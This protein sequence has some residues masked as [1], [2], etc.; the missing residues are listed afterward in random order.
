MSKTTEITA[1]HTPR[2]LAELAGRGRLPASVRNKS[3]MA[4]IDH[5]LE[6]ATTTDLMAELAVEELYLMI[7]DVGRA[8][9]YPL[10]EFATR[11]QLQGL[12]DLDMWHKG[13]P[14]VTRWLEWLD[15]TFA[16][17]IDTAIEFIASNDDETLEWL[18]IKDVTIHGND[19]D[20]ST[21]DDAFALLES[22]DGMYYVTIPQEHELTERLPQIMRL[23][24][25]AD[26]DRARLIFD[27]ARFDLPASV[28]EYMLGFRSGRLQD[29]GFLSEAEAHTVFARLNAR[30]LRAEVRGGLD[31]RP[32]VRP[33]LRG[34]ILE[35]L[36]LRGV[37]PPNLLGAALAELGDSARAAF[38]EA[39]TYLVNQVFM[40]TTGDLSRTDDLPTAG[41][42]AAALVNLGLA[43]VSD[44]HV[45]TAARALT[46]VWP[47]ELFRAGHTLTWEVGLR[48][49][50]V[51][52]RAGVDRGLALFGSPIDEALHGLA[53]PHPLY[54]MA[55]D[56]PA[57]PDFRPLSTLEELA[58]V[59]VLVEDADHVLRFFEAQLGFTPERVFDA[60]AL[61]SLSDQARRDVRL[62]TLLRTGL[63]HALL[64]DALSFDPVGREELAAFARAAF[65]RE[66]LLSAPF[67]AALEA[68]V[69]GSGDAVASFVR[70]SVDAFV[71]AMGRVAPED[72]D[73][74]FA[75]ELVLV[76]E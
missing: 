2:D 8:D 6:L 30:D 40:A 64:T 55:I 66:G 41:R 14:V 62:A 32:E 1:P 49:R 3:G 20:T 44:D 28:E 37:T 17:S 9:A 61:A 42:H 15:L 50:R 16:A 54:A 11:E 71:D 58:R 74:R 47:K 73:P 24:W 13:A 5:L 68:M 10:L 7:Q 29:M 35:D 51:Q 63:V 59:E 12:L 70:R 60:P 67:Q 56:D 26:A 72:I 69:A 57:R 18:F 27:Q 65:T 46:R 53:L 19:L 22:P 39:F 52:R 38:A 76:R 25:A 43:Y 21:V 23:M 34:A 45:E 31:D 75:G 33:A 48:A 36:V 4:R